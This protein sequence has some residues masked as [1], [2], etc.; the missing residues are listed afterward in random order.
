MSESINMWPAES[1]ESKFGSRRDQ[2]S[3]KLEFVLVG[4]SIK[5]EAE[6]YA[7]ANL[8]PYDGHRSSDSFRLRWLG[9]GRTG[10]WLVVANYKGR[11]IKT[12]VEEPD[13]PN[14][15]TPTTRET[16]IQFNIGGNSELMTHSLQTMDRVDAPGETAPDFKQQIN[17][18]DGKPEGV[19]VNPASLAESSFT[20]DLEVPL[21]LVTNEALSAIETTARCVNSITFRGR[22]R[23]EV[24]FWGLR[25][26]ARPGEVYAD[27]SFEF[28]VRKN[29]TYE[30][31]GVFAPIDK[32]GWEYVWI[33]QEQR[34]DQANELVIEKPVGLYV[35]R[36]FEFDAF[37]K[38]GVQP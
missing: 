17:V 9:N 25:G 21:E 12:V 23:G 38:L 26:T 19:E 34:E 24:L 27:L 2:D 33:Y 20:I 8:P 10:V 13:D 7:L 6:A 37:D 18:I 35:E 32:L 31:I 36:L 5:S 15:P 22:P 30:F 14:L 11:T 29:I 4:T 16:G 28:F 3:S 1:E